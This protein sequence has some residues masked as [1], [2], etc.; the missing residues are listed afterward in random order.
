MTILEGTR[1][2]S[3]Y[4]GDLQSGQLLTVLADVLTNTNVTSAAGFTNN[5]TLTIESTATTAAQL[6]IIGGPLVNQSAGI[7][8]FN[9][10]T[11]NRLLQ[12]ELD[13]A[14]SVNINGNASIGTTAKNQLNTGTIMASATATFLGDTFTNQ[15]GGVIRGDGELNVA[16]I[17]FLNEG[18]IA[19][20]ISFSLCARC[21]FVSLQVAPLPSWP[22]WRSPA[23]WRG[24]GRGF[25][26]CD[27]AVAIAIEEAEVF[28]GAVELLPRDFVIAVAVESTNPVGAGQLTVSTHMA[29]WSI[30]VIEL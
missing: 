19:P 5:S 9:G 24:A 26:G 3:N 16:A 17:S 15:L 11:G 22:W 4:S 6:T 13:N 25:V 29:R 20:S 27:G 23:V 10:A 12:A 8:D 18:E 2:T 14:G 21:C 28:C 7:I 30:W 1:G